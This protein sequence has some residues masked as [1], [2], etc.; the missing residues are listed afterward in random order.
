[1]TWITGSNKHITFYEILQK[2]KSH[3]QKNGQV[4]VG[5]DSLVLK[6]HCTF[7]T[8]IVLLGA[9]G[10]KGGKY[11][12]NKERFDETSRFYNRLLREVEKSINIAVKITEVCPNINLEVHLDVSP[13][14]KNEKSSQLAKMLIGYTTGSG[15]KCKVKPESFAASTVADRHTK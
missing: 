13:E 1:M 8:C 10:Q 4:F 12:Y 2:I 11:F 5:T 7:T 9:D 3:H 14:E 6:K 15:F